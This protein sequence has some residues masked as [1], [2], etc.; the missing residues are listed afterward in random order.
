MSTQEIASA[1]KEL[2]AQPHEGW[3]KDWVPFLDDDNGNYRCLDVNSAGCP[4]VE[5]WRGR[6]DH[7]VIAPSLAAWLSDFVR[8]LEQGAYA[9]DS[10][11]GILARRS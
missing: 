5:C 4:V 10:E 2:D 7:P 11:R 8:G 3:R 9:E 1:K 6:A